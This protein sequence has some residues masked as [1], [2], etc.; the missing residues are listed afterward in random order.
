MA[1]LKITWS[2][3]VVAVTLAVH[4]TL[5]AGDADAAACLRKAFGKTAEGVLQNKEQ[6]VH[7]QLDACE[8]FFGCRGLAT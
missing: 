5:S 3:C 4:P 7:Y 8:S 6:K 2:F 1:S